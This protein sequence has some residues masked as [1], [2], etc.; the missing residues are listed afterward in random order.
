[1]P[2]V[3]VVIKSK[4]E[5]STKAMQV[6]GMFDCPPNERQQL[7]WHIDCPIEQRPWNIGLI[8]GA[9]GSGKTTIA[10]SVWGEQALKP[11]EWKEKSIIDDF[12]AALN[13]GE[14]TAALS[15]VGFNTVPAWLRPYA[16]LSNGEK[17]RSDIARKLVEPNTDIIVVDEFTSVVDRQ[18]AK[19][20][21]HAVQKSIRKNK[22]Q[23]VAV[24]CHRDII[25]WLQPDWVIDAGE[26]T[27]EWGLV[28]QRPNLQ[29]EI[30]GIPYE[31]W[32][33]FAPF[34]YLTS[35]L[36]RG[37]QCFGLWVNGEL[38]AFA[39][40]LH[41]PH[42][43]T[44]MVR[45]LSRVVCLPD[46]Q[47]LGLAFVLMEH[48]AS[49]YKTL[50]YRF[51]TYPAHPNFVRAFDRN[52]WMMIKPPG[53]MLQGQHVRSAAT[54]KLIHDSWTGCRPCAVFRYVGKEM[55]MDDAK[56]LLVKVRQEKN[57]A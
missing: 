19:V 38:A 36:H 26:Q 9:S 34:H 33:I 41:R 45:A 29:I 2:I 43:A 13:I 37:S 53:K 12:P 42:H 4:V 47:G 30:A 28:R 15:S 25:E 1:M 31:A 8:V 48:I 39:G 27:F 55:P 3:D 40:T 24:S 14:I 23:L 16:V 6:C 20:A 44:K 32:K 54:G 50:G 35:T 46:F 57:V 18:V 49:A 22:K 51:H 7:S 11:V 17:F 52:K 21:S 5:I 10:R 56:K